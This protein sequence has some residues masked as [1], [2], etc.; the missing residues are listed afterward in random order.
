MDVQSLYAEYV[1]SVK[2]IDAEKVLDANIKF[3]LAFSY[4]KQ[5]YSYNLINK[6]QA[7]R[8]KRYYA[9]MFGSNLILV[10]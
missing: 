2:S 1:N 9:E 3:L 8:A 6:K 7:E 5:L 10:I 4:I